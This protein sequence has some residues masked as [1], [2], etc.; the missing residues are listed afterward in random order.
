M[1]DVLPDTTTEDVVFILMIEPRIFPANKETICSP[2]TPH[3]LSSPTVASYKEVLWKLEN[4]LLVVK[5]TG[6]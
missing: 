6:R 3:T 4:R 1:A 5:M 2:P